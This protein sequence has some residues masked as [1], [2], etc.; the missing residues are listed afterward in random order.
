MKKV[1]SFFLSFLFKS[2][3]KGENFCLCFIFAFLG[4]LSFSG[5]V[6][7][8]L[9][10]VPGPCALWRNKEEDSVKPVAVSPVTS[11]TKHNSF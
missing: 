4:L 11:L 3:L 10:N 1:K 7:L 6:A 2:N 5:S 8:S 9:P